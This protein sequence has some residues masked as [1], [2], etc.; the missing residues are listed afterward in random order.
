MTPKK[1]TIIIE[2]YL[3]TSSVFVLYIKI[4]YT[5]T[6]WR[7]KHFTFIK[8][9]LCDIDVYTELWMMMM[10]ICLCCWFD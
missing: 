2:Y 1:H 6:V 3:L 4:T 7:L 5:A 9:V 10:M 8:A